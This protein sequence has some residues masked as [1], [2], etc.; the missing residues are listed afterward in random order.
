MSN[1]REATVVLEVKFH[2]PMRYRRGNNEDIDV[3]ADKDSFVLNNDMIRSEHYIKCE[4]IQRQF[5]Y[6]VRTR[7]LKAPL[8]KGNYLLSVGVLEEVITRLKEFAAEY[9]QSADLLAADWQRIYD[10]A[11]AR[12]RKLFN[13]KR[14]PDPSR[15]RMAFGVE[16]R[17]LQWNVPDQ[18]TLGQ[19]LYEEEAAKAKQ[20]WKETEQTVSLGLREAL[21]QLIAKLATALSEDPDGKR[22]LLKQPAVDKINDFLDTFSKRNV[23]NDSQMM[24]LVEQAKKVIAGR[25]AEDLRD[26]KVKVAGE[27]KKIEAKLCTMIEKQKRAFDFD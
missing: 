8:Q 26:D 21:F 23:L 6:F 5:D 14:F 11:Q 12:L 25:G 27:F 16:W 2:K 7:K 15:V 3:D 24:K 18:A 13:P 1:I 4:A 17:V 9:N 19:V 22:K 10:D 20:M